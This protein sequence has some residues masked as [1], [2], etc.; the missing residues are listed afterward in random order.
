MNLPEYIKHL[1]NQGIWSFTYDDAQKNVNRDLPG[2]IQ[3]MRKAGRIID[4]A[5]GFY[6]IIP[7][8]ISLTE[9]MPADRFINDLMIHHK[10][11]YYV[12]LLT[13]AAYYG[14][15]HQSP[16]VFQ[17]ITDPYR[18]AISVRG[19][20]VKF[21]N[22]KNILATPVRQRNTPTGIMNISTPE[23]TLFDLIKFSRLIG[24]MD[25]VANVISEMM[26]HIKIPELKEAASTFPFPVLQRAGH[27]FELMEYH[28]GV[29]MLQK[30][31]ANK[32][33]VFT[34]L[35]A[36]GPSIRDPKDEK[37]KVILNT[38]IEIEY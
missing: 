9:R 3:R 28:Q 16:Q 26:E 34:P 22:K 24:G 31:L 14:S 19:G 30:F 37:W 1:N 10:S 11:S 20:R 35:E 6:A 12:G 23:A 18:R 15:S 29:I 13:A 33:L 38:E 21:F 7:E 36:S 8:E 5:R 25:H 17:V 32:E 27:V 2:A 4:P